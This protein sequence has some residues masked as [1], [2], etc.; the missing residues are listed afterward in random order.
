MNSYFFLVYILVSFF[1]NLTG[2]LYTYVAFSE[3]TG[4]KFTYIFSFVVIGISMAYFIAGVVLVIV[5]K[6][7]ADSTKKT[8]AIILLIIGF[9]LIIVD[10]I[11]A[12]TL[13]GKFKS[14]TMPNV[15]DKTLYTAIHFATAAARIGLTLLFCIIVSKELKAVGTRRYV[16]IPCGYEYK[17]H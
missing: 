6:S 11:A 7:K 3:E 4:D 10:G 17:F 5:M 12:Y 9:V 15:S 1:L 13:N 16:V 14:D 2:T 8:V